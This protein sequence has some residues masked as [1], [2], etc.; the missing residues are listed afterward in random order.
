MGKEKQST[1]L[2]RDAL[3]RWPHQKECLKQ[4]RSFIQ[5]RSTLAERDFFVQIATGAGKSLVMADLLASPK[6]ACVIVPKLDLMEQ[7]A[8]LLEEI[9]PSKRISRVGTG[10][11]A[12]LTADIFVCVDRSAFRLADLA[13]DLIL[14]D[15]AHHYEQLPGI[16]NV[17]TVEHPG[18]E[19]TP[20]QQVLALK[21][22]KRIFFTATLTK[23]SP[24]FDFGLR[25]AIE[26]GVIQDYSVMVPVLSE[27]DPTDPVWSS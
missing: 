2:K 20:T 4:C 24:D 13:F 23:N 25:P 5:N 10:C 27:G 12:D 14:L 19:M 26:A 1:T 16:S 22:Q 11:S 17:E 18:D 7:M 15:E 6:R 21:A 3:K 9:Y 8:Q